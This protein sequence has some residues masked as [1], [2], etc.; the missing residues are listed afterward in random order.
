[1]IGPTILDQC[2]QNTASGIQFTSNGVA[3]T[4]PLMKGQGVN[5]VCT[6]PH[7]YSRLFHPPPDTSPSLP[8]SIFTKAAGSQAGRGLSLMPSLLLVGNH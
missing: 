7:L 6:D 2:G 3:N 4:R 5:G 8:L 1:M